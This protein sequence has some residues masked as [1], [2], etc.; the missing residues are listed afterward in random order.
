MEKAAELLFT[1]EDSE[2]KELLEM[3]R[4]TC[5]AQAQTLERKLSLT[6]KVP[7]LNLSFLKLGQAH[8]H[9]LILRMESPSKTSPKRLP[10]ESSYTTFDNS[11]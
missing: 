2:L 7:T 1:S 3:L 10:N 6:T 11:S 5:Q 4:A 8:L 9:T